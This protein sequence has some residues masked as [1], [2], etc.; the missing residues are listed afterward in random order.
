MV[1]NDPINYVDVLGL[2]LTIVG[3]ANFVNQIGAQ[4]RAICSFVALGADGT[5][6]SM[7]GP[8]SSRE[9]SSCCCLGKLIENSSDNKIQGPNRARRSPTHAVPNKFGDENPGADGKPGPGTP[10]TVYVDDGF[11]Y[12]TRD[13]PNAPWKPYSPASILANELC[14]HVLRFNE[15]TQVKPGPPK[16]PGEPPA[17]EVDA[18]DLENEINRE[19]GWPESPTDQSDSRVRSR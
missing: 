16:K 8:P 15:G 6:I 7:Q 1:L 11:I 9:T 13:N 17:H 10:G 5:V 4:I 19:H 18:Q 2:K 14:G 3:D 12:E